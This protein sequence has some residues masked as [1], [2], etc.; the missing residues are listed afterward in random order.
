MRSGVISPVEAPYMLLTAR[1][2][3]GISH[4][5]PTNT[6]GK[7]SLS[8]TRSICLYNG[9]IDSKLNEKIRNR[10]DPGTKDAVDSGEL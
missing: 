9:L 10:N 7:A 8:L 3:W 1:M 2:S 5:L 4:L 6:I